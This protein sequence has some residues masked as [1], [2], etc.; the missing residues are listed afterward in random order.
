MAEMD[1]QYQPVAPDPERS[2]K[3]CKH[4]EADFESGGAGK[5][6]G[7]D[8]SAEGTCNVFEAKDEENPHSYHA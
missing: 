8:V 3:N 2:C 6:F 5:C 4:F 1:V 7:K